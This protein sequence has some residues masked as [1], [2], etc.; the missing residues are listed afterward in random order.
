M[1]NIEI[2]KKKCTQCSFCI[3]DCPSHAIDQDKDGFPQLLR[4]S[5]LECQHCL[6]ICPEAAL[7]FSGYKPENSLPIS[8]DRLPNIEQLEVLAKGRRSIRSYK[9]ADI[10]REEIDK[11]LDI[12]YHAPTGKNAKGISFKVIYKGKEMDRFISLFYN[13]I[14]D[15]V[16]DGKLTKG[17]EFLEQ[18]L[19]SYKNNNNDVF[20]RNAP[21]IFFAIAEEDTPLMFTD[22]I[23]SGSY[24]ELA[25]TAAGYGGLWN[26]FVSHAVKTIPQINELLKLKDSETFCYAISFGIPDVTYSR[27]V[28]RGNTKV[29]E[30]NFI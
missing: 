17:N 5:C 13:A 11:I 21:H 8:K 15:A 2:N 20:F 24:F 16:N 14:E 27:T 19:N 30:I 12:A 18:L 28:Q 6:A 9:K 22:S 7:S 25:L 23:I 29:E 3:L 1:I 10:P 26:G 4:D